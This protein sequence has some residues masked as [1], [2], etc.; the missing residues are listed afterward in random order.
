M[1]GILALHLEFLRRET[2]STPVGHGHHNSVE[3]SSVM[4]ITLWIKA[5]SRGERPSGEKR[6][7]SSWCVKGQS[8]EEPDWLWP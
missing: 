1:L 8:R 4:K 2:L 7:L 6:S 3:E 5:Q